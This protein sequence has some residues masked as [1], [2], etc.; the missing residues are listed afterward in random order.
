MKIQGVDSLEHKED[1]MGYATDLRDHEWAIL[2]P[3]LE[4]KQK[5]RPRKHGLREICDAVRYVQRTGC[6][7]RMLP[8]DFPPWIVVYMTFWRWR[9]RGLWEGSM[10]E[11]RRRVRVKAG[12]NPD[13]SLAIIDSQSVKTVQK[14]GNAGTTAARKRRD[15]SAISRSM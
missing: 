15:A 4:P 11:L 10:H 9:N 13:P 1:G 3:L 7:W 12:R 8:P 2:E 5:G 6:Q 14:G